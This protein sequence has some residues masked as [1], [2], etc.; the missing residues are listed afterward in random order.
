MLQG[1]P[2]LGVNVQG[3]QE[4]LTACINH[5]VKYDFG[6]K[7][8]EKSLGKLPIPFSKID[9]SGYVRSAIA[10]ASAGKIITPDGSWNQ[11]AWLQAH[12]YKITDHENCQLIDNH[13][14]ICVH[15][16]DTLDETGHVWFVLNGK[17]MESWG[18]HG[19]G[20]RPWNSPLHSGVTLNRLATLTFAVL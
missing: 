11:G 18:G 16:S 8:P 3:L 14:R 15:H 4:Y 1:Y 12:G 19:P 20:S 7:C 6:A 9:C 10:H 5:G 13:L 2:N 17:T